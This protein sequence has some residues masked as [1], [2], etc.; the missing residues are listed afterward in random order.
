MG[1]SLVNFK[2]T[3]SVSGQEVS[4]HYSIPVMLRQQRGWKFASAKE[5]G[6]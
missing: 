1:K 6:M 3:L 5:N 2:G 4:L